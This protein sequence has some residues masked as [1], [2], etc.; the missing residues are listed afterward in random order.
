MVFDKGAFEEKVE[1]GLTK[2]IFGSKVRPDVFEAL[3]KGEISVNDLAR[4]LN[5]SVATLLTSIAPLL[6]YRIV[7]ISLGTEKS[8]AL[9]HGVPTNGKTKEL[10]NELAKGVIRTKETIKKLSQQIAESENG[11]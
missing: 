2:A 6:P 7:N 1:K 3:L 5:V 8:I 9:G 10:V 4:S 11:S